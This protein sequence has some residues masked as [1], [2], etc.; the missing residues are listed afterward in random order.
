MDRIAEGRTVGSDARRSGSVNSK[1]G[2]EDGAA[3]GLVASHRLIAIVP[4]SWTT[5]LKS[6]PTYPCARDA[7]E[8]R[9]SCVIE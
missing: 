6:A 4:A 2:E 3:D 1:F 9:S 7:T 5:A 8:R